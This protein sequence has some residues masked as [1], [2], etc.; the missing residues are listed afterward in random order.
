MKPKYEV[1]KEFEILRPVVMPLTPF[2]IWVTNRG[3]DL[4]WFLAPY[5][6]RVRISRMFMP[7]RDGHKIKLTIF[8]PKDVAEPMPGLVYFCGGGFM[9]SPSFAHKRNAA[10]MAAEA[11]CKVIIAH[12][13]LAPSHPFPEGLHDCEDAFD[14]VLR[15]ADILSLDPKRIAMGG[16]SAGGTLTAG[17]TLL[18]R[19][20]NEQRPCFA[21]MMYPAL[22]RESADFPSRKKY[23]DTPM[24]NTERFAFIE[25]HYYKNGYQEMEK[26]AFPL[27]TRSYEGLPPFY[28]ETAE[29]DCLHDDGLIAA[30][31]LRNAGIEVTLVET[32]GT[33]HGYDAI[34]TSPVT[35]DCMRRR[36]AAL[37]KAFGTAEK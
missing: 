5:D 7:V 28:I 23:F 2:G 32:K 17:V 30:D 4:T 14:F 24:F 20:E 13:R 1:H 8:T 26:Y 12:Y 3:L 16:D 10:K 25:K 33:F 11:R 6:H 34:E 36:V 19:D 27:M 18:Q 9:M 15:N 29:F 31:T 22:E 35:K 21:M 37:Q